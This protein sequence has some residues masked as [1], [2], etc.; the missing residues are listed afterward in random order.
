VS[1]EPLA[2]QMDPFTL[3]FD[4][5]TDDPGAAAVPLED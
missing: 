4:D 3:V 2:W 5:P 1:H